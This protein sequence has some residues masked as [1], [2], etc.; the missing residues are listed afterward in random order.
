MNT[1]YE[2]RELDRLRK[3]SNEK[4][5]KAKEILKDNEKNINSHID[6]IQNNYRSR[7]ESTMFDDIVFD[8]FTMLDEG[9][10]AKQYKENKEREKRRE[11]ANEEIRLGRRSDA[12]FDSAQFKY[13]PK[14]TKTKIDKDDDSLPDTVK[15]KLKRGYHDDY[16]LTEK[17]D[18]NAAKKV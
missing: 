4:I 17:K 15:G 7:G 16:E 11:E 10:K 5:N 13:D 6:K 8:E 1:F 12:H 9:Y 14:V 18:K 3:S 2:S